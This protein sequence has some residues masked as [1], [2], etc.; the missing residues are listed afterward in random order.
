MRLAKKLACLAL[1]G[2]IAL[3]Q[4]PVTA[5]AEESSSLIVEPTKSSPYELDEEIYGAELFSVKW[6][7]DEAAGS[8][9]YY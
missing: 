1:A 6:A 9:E 3:A 8:W 5:L 2:V 7:D 4:V